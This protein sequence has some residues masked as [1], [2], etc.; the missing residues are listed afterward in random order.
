M[1]GLEAVRV[2]GMWAVAWL[3]GATCRHGRCAERREVQSRGVARC[4]TE[5]LTGLDY[6]A[7]R[8]ARPP[9]TACRE[10]IFELDARPSPTHGS[11][12]S[13]A[14]TRRPELTRAA[15]PY[16]YEVKLKATVA[17]MPAP[18]HTLRVLRCP[19]IMHAAAFPKVGKNPSQHR[20]RRSWLSLPGPRQDEMHRENSESPSLCSS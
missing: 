16:A 9:H 3:Q 20:R 10:K 15:R 6:E 18:H 5:L 4:R 7:G 14:P 2:R 13:L 17:H 8:R 19:L 1:G 11:Q 12:A